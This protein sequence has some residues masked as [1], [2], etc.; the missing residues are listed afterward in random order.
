MTEVALERLPE[1]AVRGLVGDWIA[2]EGTAA[3]VVDA[4]EGVPL[5][6]VEYVAAI[7]LDPAAL[8]GPLPRGARN[9][10]AARMAAVGP[11]ARQVLATAAVLGVPFDPDLVREASGREDEE[12]AEALEELVAAGLI[13][14]TSAGGGLAYAFTHARLRALAYEELGLARRRLLH[15]RVTAVLEGRARRTRTE[16][17]AAATIVVHARAAGDETAAA[18][19]AAVA[20][21]H[22]AG[23]LAVTEAAAHYEDALALGHP[24]RT[25]LTTAL[26]DLATLAGRYADA[27]ARYEAAA[28]LAQEDDFPAVEHRLAAVHLRRGDWV[29]ADQH[30]HVAL[31]ALEGRSAPA[32]LGLTARIRT[33]RGLLAHRQGRPD[34][35]VTEAQLALGAA[36]EAGDPAALAAA[37]NLLGVLSKGSL[38]EAR[39]HLEQALALARRMHDV[40]TEVAAA[41]N[42]AQAHAAAGDPERALL[43]A[44]SAAV[45][46][47]VLGDRHRLAA[48]ENHLADLL[49]ALGRDEEAM[50]HLKR[51]VTLFAEVDEPGAPSPEIWKLAEW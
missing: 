15:R 11:A 44:E 32:D 38:P 42:L 30:L 8:D 6:V 27:V 9:L 31:A 17:A 5:L 33:D 24:E 36:Q 35:A 50:E 22:A 21:D 3:R 46:A 18:R 39:H 16:G 4:A 43:L 28:A 48:L 51:A 29:L 2:D 25:R 20:G 7:A 37:H 49:R 34:E 41:N 19:W 47:K 1:A 26:G 10:F 14:E 40:G 45:R 23:L 13:G 12:A